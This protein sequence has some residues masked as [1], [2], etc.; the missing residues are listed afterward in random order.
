MNSYYAT[1]PRC[2][3]KFYKDE[4]WKKVCL[5]CWL[6]TKRKPE[7]SSDSYVMSLKSEIRNLRH[8]VDYYEGYCRQ[9][10]QENAQKANGKFAGHI[11]DLIFLC[12]PDKHN[13]NPKA[14]AVTAWLLEARKELCQ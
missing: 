12:H 1:C 2:G 10:E 11:K 4:P 7:T 13:N 5:D 8:I 3:A 9:L 6:K 14:T